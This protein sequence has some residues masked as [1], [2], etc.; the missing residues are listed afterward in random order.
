MFHIG[1][2]GTTKNAHTQV[3]RT[4]FLKMGFLRDRW[5]L[6]SFSVVDEFVQ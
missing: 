2:K 6:I 1:C 3:L 4:L 5:A